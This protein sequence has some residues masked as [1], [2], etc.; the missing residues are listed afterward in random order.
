MTNGN[1]RNNSST[2][3]ILLTAF[4]IVGAVFLA[5]TLLVNNYSFSNARGSSPEASSRLSLSWWASARAAMGGPCAKYVDSPEAAEHFLENCRNPKSATALTNRGRALLIAW[6]PNATKTEKNQYLEQVAESF[7][8]A[9]ELAPNDPQSAFYKAFVLDFKDFVIDGAD[10][11]CIP[12]GER[13]E[14]AVQLYKQVDKITEDSHSLFILNELGHFL[15]NRDKDYKTAIDLYE[16]VEPE[17]PQVGDV[18]MSKATAQLLDKDYFGAK[19][20]FEAV[21]AINPDAYQIKYNLGS[22]WAQLDN[23]EESLKYYKDIT[24]NPSTSNFYYAW[25]DQGIAYY[26][27]GRYSDAQQSFEQALTF[28]GAAVF[29]KKNYAFMQNALGCLES[30]TAVAVSDCFQSSPG[31]LK[32]TLR[33]SGVFQGSVIVHNRNQQSDPFFEVEHDAF[34]KCNQV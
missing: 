10:K 27:L 3:F 15:I 30:S 4:G 25:R 2:V 28:S 21:L 8:N 5:A 32:A 20:S 16:K 11:T 7:N 6:E 23:Y 14:E 13:Y 34:Y 1:N 17:H 24:Q 19:D 31:V 29:D 12:A 26:F 18:L 33:E 22:L 9:S